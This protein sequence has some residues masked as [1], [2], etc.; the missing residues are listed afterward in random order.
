MAQA[1]LFHF[2][3]KAICFEDFAQ[4]EGRATWWASDLSAMLGYSTPASFKKAVN[5][6]ITACT[7]L[8][9][10][11]LDHFQAASKPGF[12]TDYR[13]TRF[14][15]LLVVMNADARKPQVNK[16]QV[17]F[18]AI[19]DKIGEHLEAVEGVDRILKRGEISEH[20][21]SLSSTA[22]AAGV[23]GVGYARFQNAGYLGLYNM[24]I[25]HLKK[26]KGVPNGRTP[27]DFMGSAELA[28]NLFRIT[29]TEEKIKNQSIRGQRNLENTA[30]SVGAKV[31]QTM[32][33][34]SGVPP[35]MLRPGEDIKKVRTKLRGTNRD[36]DRI[37]SGKKQLP[38][39]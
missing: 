3:R 26:V 38:E 33:D 18:A 9:I 29:Q 36:F 35:E 28:A 31:R 10:M 21:K 17:Y 5:R 23:R 32:I 4:D 37:D 8:D 39:S 11:P 12:G 20:E 19:A 7:R 27:L 2:D 22:A 15:C 16:A 1:D 13:L 30:Q 14:A 6:A 25:Q 24:S 34:I